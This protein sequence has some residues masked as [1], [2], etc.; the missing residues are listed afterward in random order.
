[1]SA[2]R[3]SIM[4]PQRAGAPRRDAGPSSDGGPA[5]GAA[6]A[7]I[8]VRGE[9]GQSSVELIALLPL[10]LIVALGVA[11]LLGA[12]AASGQA[13]AAAQAGAMAILQD[14]DPRAAAREALP[15]AARGRSTVTV[16]GHQ[17]A[18]EVRP[19]TLLPF[20]SATLAASASASAGAAP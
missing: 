12:R 11:S 15:V 10:V 7:I 1:M 18:V 9:G 20:L 16:R 8:T 3:R 17:V 14:E 2:T 4:A 13:A 19:R 6:R 5:A